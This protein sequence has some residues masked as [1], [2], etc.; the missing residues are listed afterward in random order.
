[1]QF[2][3]AYF[4]LLTTKF[5]LHIV[6]SPYTSLTSLLTFRVQHLL[7]LYSLSNLI[8]PPPSFFVYILHGP[9][10]FPHMFSAVSIIV[11][12]ICCHCSCTPRCCYPF[13]YS[14]S[15]HMYIFLTSVFILQFQCLQPSF[16]FNSSLIYS[17]LPI[18]ALPHILHLVLQTLDCLTRI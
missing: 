13:S 14:I 11:F 15:S 18:C 10:H 6:Y 1:M 8:I 12:F 5:S 9:F 3:S 16:K 17:S 7:N 4:P 2:L